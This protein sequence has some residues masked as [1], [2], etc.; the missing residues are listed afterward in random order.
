[1]K[2]LISSVS[3]ETN[4]VYIDTIIS[5]SYTSAI[6]QAIQIPGISGMENN[7][8]LF[9]FDKENP[10]GLTDIIDNFNLVHAGHFD[11][12]I[13]AASRK[14]VK[15]KN[16][17]HV[18]IKTIDEDNANLMILTS[19]IISGHPNWTKGNMNIFHICKQDELKET[20]RKMDEL[21]ISGRLPIS[22]QNIEIIIQQADVSPK[23]LINQYSADAGLTILGFRTETVNHS[24]EVIFSGYDELGSILFVNAH[25][26]KVID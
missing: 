5:P 11:V 24:R 2:R 25:S 15:F 14:P 12:C 16:G 19:F 4:N 26:R 13:L 23:T 3:D 6:A 9:E 10:I 20:K 21:V 7:M 1:M 17:I 22:A 8:I 18:W